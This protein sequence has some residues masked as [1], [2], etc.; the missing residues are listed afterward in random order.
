MAS[1]LDSEECRALDLPT[2]DVRKIVGRFLTVCYE[3]R[4]T[5]PHKMNGDE[6]HAALGHDLP[7]RF[8]R[9]DALAESVPDVL[10]G[11]LEH[12]NQTEVVTNA[13]EMKSAFQSTIDEFRSAVRTGNSHHC[14]REHQEPFEHKASKLGRNDPC[15]CG[16]GKKFKKCHGKG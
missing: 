2:D 10:A 9:G 11:Y 5:A 13:Y 4:G 15:F 6:M 16:S 3:D 12:L 14:H 7:G 1:F 8:K